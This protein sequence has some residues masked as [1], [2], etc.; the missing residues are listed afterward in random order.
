ML[1][2]SRRTV[3]A[4]GIVASLAVAVPMTLAATTS[5]S[6]PANKAVAAGSHRVVS[7]PGE[8]VTLMSTTFKT[9]KPEDLLMT[10]SLECSILTA[11]TTDNNNPSADAQS[12]ARIWIEIDGKIVPIQD[13]SAPPQ[14]PGAGGSDADKVTFCNREY[15]RTVT[16]GETPADG[17]DTQDDFI[18]TKSA[19]AFSWVSLNAGSGTHTAVVYAELTTGTSG[20]NAQA[21]LDIGNRTFIV[22]PTKLANNAVISEAGTG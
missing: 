16:D 8:K 17:I 19:H 13:V 2:L 11:L 5:S 12:A 7:A 1:N 14:N 22:E 15:S 10:V 18:K 6:Q 9:S 4:T 21:T 3:V 20:T